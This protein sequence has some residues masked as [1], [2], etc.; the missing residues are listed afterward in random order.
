MKQSIRRFLIVFLLSAT[1]TTATACTAGTTNNMNNKDEDFHIV[2]SFYPMYV[3]T[4]NIVGTTPGVSI[5]NM[6]QPQ[7]GCLHDYSLKPSDLKTLETADAFVINGAGMESFL[8]KVLVQYTNLTI[9]EAGKDIPLLKDKNGETNP[10]IWVSVSGAIAEVK[11][12]AKQLSVADPIHAKDYNNNAESYI[13]SLEALSKTMHESLSPYEGE[14]IVT[15]HEAFPYFADEFKLLIVAVIEREPG[16]EPGAGELADTLNIIRE[17]N[18]H[19]LFAE[20]QYS[21]R[22]AQT[23]ADETGAKIY[24]LDPFVTGSTDDPLDRYQTVMLENM[25]TLISALGQ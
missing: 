11:Q 23:I 20:P 15:F 2:T 19:A 18:V 24:S 16:S 17:K 9:I 22:A 12:I 7:T 10:H 21:T 6:T 5:E 4:K 3:F 1:M 13:E 25:K 14:A 8:D